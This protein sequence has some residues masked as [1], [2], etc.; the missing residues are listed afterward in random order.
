MKAVLHYRAEADFRALIDTLAPPW[1]QIAIVP[2][3][4]D[5]MLAREMRDADVLLHVL[6]P[7]T[8][9]II[10]GAPQLRL[11][12]KIGVGVNTIDLAM[13]QARGVAVCNMPG[14]NTQAVA[15]LTL[16]LML[17]SLRRIVRLDGETRAGRGWSAEPGFFEGL[18]EIAGRTVGLVGFGAVPQRLAPVLK[19]LGAKV[20]CYARHPID[21]SSIEQVP[22]SRL[23]EMA[24]IVSLHLPVTDET[25][26]IV[27]SQALVGMKADAILIN[28]ARG[29]LVD[30][31]AL[32]GALRDG[33]IAGAGLDVFALEPLEPS[34][35]LLGL[36][37][38]VVTPHIAWLTQETL[39]RSLKT[40]I[41]NCHRLHVAEPLLNVVT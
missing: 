38:V 29:G 14:T 19:A 10:E 34:N 18:G 41:E 25:A 24:D 37:N 28:T 22:L 9:A 32:I 20:I 30:E 39:A 21:D 1:L 2:E 23:L 6:A 4:E 33:Q 40:A 16:L 8:A 17:A 31:Q 5:A 3:A 26:E 11:I 12:Q 27:S 35:P 36:S 13:A 15:E 7:V